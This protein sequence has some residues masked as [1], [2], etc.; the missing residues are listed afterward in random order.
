MV[1]EDN[2]AGDITN[3]NTKTTTDHGFAHWNGWLHA[4]RF[5]LGVSWR[6]VG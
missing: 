6:L 5:Y 1:A 2:L 3:P 4:S